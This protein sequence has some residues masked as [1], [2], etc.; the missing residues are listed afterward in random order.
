MKSYS[1][2]QL[3]PSIDYVIDRMGDDMNDRDPNCY[4]YVTIIFHVLGV[5]NNKSHK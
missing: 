3:V 4:S 2:M 5:S 1:G